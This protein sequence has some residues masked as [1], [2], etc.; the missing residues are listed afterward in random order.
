MYTLP[1]A[2]GFWW[3]KILFLQT[4]FDLIFQWVYYVAAEIASHYYYYSF[5]LLFRIPIKSEQAIHTIHSSLLSCRCSFISFLNTDEVWLFKSLT[6]SF[7]SLSWLLIT[8]WIWLG[9]MQQAYISRPFFC[10]PCCQH[11]I[12]SSLYSF[13]V[14]TSIQFTV[15]NWWSTFWC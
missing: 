14:K 5:C 12:I 2:T 1:N 13:L 3:C 15:E 11:F 9:I 7:N 8:K 10:W 4:S 6:I